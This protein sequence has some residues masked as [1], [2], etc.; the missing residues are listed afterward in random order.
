MT[1]PLFAQAALSESSTLTLGLAL[2]LF[3]AIVL[4]VWWGG[5]EYQ[6][7][8]ERDKVLA[9]H[10]ERLNALEEW[11][12]AAE[13]QAGQI[14]AEMGELRRLL[15]SISEDVKDI[16]K[17]VHEKQYDTRPKRTGGST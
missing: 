16:R 8:V 15:A 9:T 3:S 1:L 2:G 7:G 4:G 12:R 5:R 17:V 11:R 6:R 13:V 14:R 10:A